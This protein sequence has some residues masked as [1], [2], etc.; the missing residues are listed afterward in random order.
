MCLS[1]SQIQLTF[2]LSL[3]LK[4]SCESTPWALAQVGPADPVDLQVY[5]R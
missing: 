5:P 2:I 3:R 4:G 1:S